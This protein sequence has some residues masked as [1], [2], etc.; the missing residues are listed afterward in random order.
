[1]P[2]RAS[3]FAFTTFTPPIESTLRT[4]H[5]PNQHKSKVC[6]GDPTGFAAKHN[7]IFAAAPDEGHFALAHSM[8]SSNTRQAS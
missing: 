6:W 2:H 3:A 5:L 4:R 1:M 7:Q 8:A